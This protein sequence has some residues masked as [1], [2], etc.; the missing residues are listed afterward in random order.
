MLGARRIEHQIDAAAIDAFARQLHPEYRM[1]K[2][3]LER[4]LFRSPKHDVLSPVGNAKIRRS[5]SRR[6]THLQFLL[7]IR[8]VAGPLLRSGPA[9]SNRSAAASSRP[10]PPQDT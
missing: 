3:F 9:T 1:F 7:S 2:Q 5:R 8:V 6:P 4:I 10:V